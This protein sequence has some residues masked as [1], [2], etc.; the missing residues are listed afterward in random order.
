V[1][2]RF[3]LNADVGEGYPFD[4]ELL[5][6]ITSANVA[7]GFH[8]G[9]ATTMARTCRLAVERGVAIGAQVSYRD[10][11]GFGRRDVEIAPSALEA[12]LG[13]QVLALQDAATSA[14]GAVTYLKPHG[15]LYNRAVHDDEHAAAVVAVCDSFDLPVLGLPGSRLLARA[16]EGGVVSWREFFADRAYDAAGRLVSRRSAGAVITDPAE[17]VGRVR[18]LVGSST[19]ATVEGGVIRVAADSICVHGDTP[20][21]ADL[22]RRVRAALQA[23]GVTVA[24]MG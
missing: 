11:E 7:C 15:A 18:A 20:G 2:P 13:E 19:V 17:V 16:A 6:T 14:G 21:A 1:E 10:R 12:D 8:A 24:P 4:E 3:D 9:D 22:A 23:E 5:A